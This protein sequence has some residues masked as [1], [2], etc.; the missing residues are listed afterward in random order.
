MGQ[1]DLAISAHKKALKVRPYHVGAHNN[2]GVCYNRKG[3][4]DKA[5]S[6]FEHALRID[7]VAHFNLGLSYQ[8]MGQLDLAISA[9]KKALKVRPYYV[10]AH[11]NLG[12]C[13]YKKGLIEKAILQFNKAIQ[14]KR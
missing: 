6:E 3:W 8:K 1:L 14:T 12:V 11:N 13:Y 5:M 9:H 4:V 7:P 10:G 2:L